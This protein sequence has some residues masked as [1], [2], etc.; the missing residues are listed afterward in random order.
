MSDEQL[1]IKQ[2]NDIIIRRDAVIGQL[3]DDN[4]RL[5]ELYIETRIKHAE[6]LQLIV[7]MRNA[8]LRAMVETGLDDAPKIIEADVWAKAI[9]LIEQTQ[10]QIKSD[11]LD[12]SKQ[13]HFER[14]KELFQQKASGTDGI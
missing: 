7:K 9:Q 5:H 2:L 4:K 8:I 1:E 11:F 6:A 10:E 13:E 14:L 12:K 3:T